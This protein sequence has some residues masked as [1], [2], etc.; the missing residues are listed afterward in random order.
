[1]HFLSRCQDLPPS[2]STVMGSDPLAGGD[3]ESWPRGI[4]MWRAV[5]QWL[6]GMG[7]LVLFVA[8]LSYLGLGSK[9][10]FCNESSFPDGR[11]KH[12][13]YS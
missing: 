5:T 4:L 10:L 6:G 11:G 8:L 3:I 13:A 1:M 7:I 2:G 12:G 9:S